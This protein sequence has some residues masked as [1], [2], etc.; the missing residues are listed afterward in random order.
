MNV[1]PNP[2]QIRA[3][4]FDAFGT[5]VNITQP[6]WPYKK[7]LQWLLEHRFADVSLGRRMMTE[8][9]SFNEMV[10]LYAQGQ[11]PVADLQ[12]RLA[13]L[14]VELDSIE[15]FPE[16]LQVLQQLKDKGYQLILCSN[17]AQPY[18]EKIKPMLPVFDAYTMSYE[19]GAIKPEPEIYHCFL[20]ELDLQPEQVLF[21]GDQKIADVDGPQQLGL[22]TEHLQRK[23]QQDLWH[24]IL[25]ML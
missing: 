25:R 7:A 14:Q 4:A 5:L 10:Q 1:H 16:S 13:E 17:L 3:V 9:I 6:H 19:V 2:H 15:L 11:Y 8:D 18:G 21:I 24:G 12:Q 23:Q 20:T 22:H